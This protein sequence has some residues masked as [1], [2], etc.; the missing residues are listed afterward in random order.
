M[1]YIQETSYKNCD[2]CEVCWEIWL[3]Q[4][5]DDKLLCSDCMKIELEWKK[6]D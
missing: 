3:L 6:Y 5:S 1:K 2:F 4:E